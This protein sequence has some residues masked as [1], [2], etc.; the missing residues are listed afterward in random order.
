MLFRSQLGAVEFYSG[1]AQVPMDFQSLELRTG[2]F[3][4]GLLVVWTRGRG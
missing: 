2:G 4:C 3:R 1:P